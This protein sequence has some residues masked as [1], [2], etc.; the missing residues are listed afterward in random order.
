[1]TP[2][3][4]AVFRDSVQL[5][6]DGCLEW[7]GRR[8][9]GGYGRTSANGR[10]IS[11]YRAAWMMAH[12]REVPDGLAIDHLCCNRAC[13][14][15]HHLEAVTTAENTRRI[16]RPPKG[17]E[18]APESVC[19]EFTVEGRRRYMVEWRAINRVT[20]KEDID[21]RAFDDE[22][23]AQAFAR[24]QRSFPTT[25][26]SVL[27]EVP[28][29]LREKINRHWYSP[30]GEQWLHAK[31]QDFGGRSP[32]DMIRCGRANDVREATASWLK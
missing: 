19:Y 29:D 28:R 22:S 2:E 12:Y 21:V 31:N 17:W 16:H 3:F 11:A 25:G 14:N 18:L 1:M 20:G 7:M 4:H 15:P 6:Q 27:E 13:V 30:Y 24:H 10:P 8:D 9:D 32:I 23:E 26:V 5:A